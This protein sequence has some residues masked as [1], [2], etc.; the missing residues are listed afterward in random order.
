MGISQAFKG[1]L[2]LGVASLG[3]TEAHGQAKLRRIE[4]RLMPAEAVEFRPDCSQPDA[5]LDSKYASNL[6]LV[7]NELASL[8]H[9]AQQFCAETAW[10]DDNIARRDQRLAQCEVTTHDRMKRDLK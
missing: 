2:L 3:F 8:Q 5:C 9:A 10:P 6:L 1:I 4:E 7:A